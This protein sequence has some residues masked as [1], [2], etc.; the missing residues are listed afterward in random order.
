MILVDGQFAGHISSHFLPVAR[1]HHHTFYTLPFQTGYRPFAVVLDAVVNDDMTCILA[2]HRHMDDRTHVLAVGPA[3]THGIHHACVAHAHHVIAHTRLDTLAGNL[4]H[5]TH[6]A[7]V[8]G[9]LGEGL[10]QGSAD[11]VGAEMLDVC[12]QMQQLPLVE[13]VRMHCRHR[14][15]SVSQRAR[16]VEHHRA[17]L[18]QDVHIVRALDEYTFARGPADTPEEGQRH[19]DDQCAGARHHQEH[20]CPVEPCGERCPE[21]TRQQGRNHGQGHGGKHH[22][23]RIHPCELSDKRLALRLFLTGI[24]H[25]SDDFRGRALAEGLRG[26]HPDDTT[27]VDTSRHHLFAAEYLARQALAR[28]RHRVERTATLHNH[29][30]ERHPLARSYHNHLAHGHSLGSHLLHHRLAAPVVVRPLHVRHVGPDIHQMGN[31]RTALPLGIALKQLAHLEE[32]HHKHR[33]GELRLSPRQET[34]AQGTDGRHRHQ[35]VLVERL[36][37]R[38]SLGSLLQRVPADEQVRHQIDQQQLP[39]SQLAPF[40]DEH[41]PSQ[42]YRRDAYQP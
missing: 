39:C 19:T 33:L 37:V 35:E 5:L 2:V 26:A 34:D 38:Q 25:Q 8:G 42:Q 40:F 10:A 3:G 9:L 17:E 20:Q 14:K 22:H 29:T 16:L 13:G 27:Q 41:G 4:L 28:Q 32:Q 36:A 21:V 31:A 7:A 6:T 23:R 18:R 1:Q 11:G 30:V 15:L 24:L 12:R